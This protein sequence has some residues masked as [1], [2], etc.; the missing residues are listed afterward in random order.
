MG[1]EAVIKELISSVIERINKK[2]LV[3]FWAKEMIE[4]I[5]KTLKLLLLV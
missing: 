5:L 1:V 4:K 3:G 2:C